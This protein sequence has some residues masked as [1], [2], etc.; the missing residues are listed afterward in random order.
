MYKLDDIVSE[1]LASKGKPENQRPRFYTIAVAGMRELH[2]DVN[3]TVKVVALTINDNDTVDLP[4]DFIRYNKIGIVGGDGRIQCLNMDSSINMNPTLDACGNSVPQ[5]AVQG[6]VNVNLYTGYFYGVNATKGGVFGLGGGQSS[7]G[8]YRLDR[9]KNQLLL[10]NM[11][12]L[13]GRQIIMEYIGDLE[14]EDQDFFV[15][16][17]VVQTIKDWISWQYIYDDRNT[18]VGEKEQKRREYFN[19]R[20]ISALRYKS[21]TPEEWASELRKSNTAAVRW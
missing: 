3:G 9:A 6:N 8:Y 21:S 20:R 12:I 7:I 18:S 15:S 1:F 16:P 11:N 19:S 17:F 13:L 2:L 14:S 10:A 5:P 4:S